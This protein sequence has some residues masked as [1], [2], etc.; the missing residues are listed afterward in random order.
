VLIAKAPKLDSDDV[1]SYDVP[2]IQRLLEAAAKRRN[3]AR[4]ALALALG[5]RQGEALGLSWADIELDEGTF[6]VRR[7]RL[8]PRY[9]HGCA[10]SCGKTPGR[11]PQR[12]AIRPATGGVKSKAGRRTIGLPP[13]LVALVVPRSTLAAVLAAVEE[14]A[15]NHSRGTAHDA[16]LLAAITDL[17]APLASAPAPSGTADETKTEPR[18]P[19]A[20]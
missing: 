4:W 12:V 13:Q 20:S 14:C 2:E 18:R 9:A 15:T 17:R 10:S 1:E 8:R 5:L 7:S 19:R 11:C 6:R 16:D 3:G